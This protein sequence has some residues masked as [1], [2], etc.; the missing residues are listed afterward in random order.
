M[1]CNDLPLYVLSWNYSNQREV[2]MASSFTAFSWCIWFIKN[3]TI[4]SIMRLCFGKKRNLFSI[5]FVWSSST[6]KK[7]PKWETMYWNNKTILIQPIDKVAKR[8]RRRRK[9]LINSKIEK[10]KENRYKEE[11]VLSETGYYMWKRETI[12][13]SRNYNKNDSWYY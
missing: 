1:R 9:Y 8:L 4:F 10:G 7:Y 2:V 13:T 3:L 11:L 12:Q 6:S 5:L